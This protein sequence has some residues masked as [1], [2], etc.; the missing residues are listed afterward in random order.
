MAMHGAKT[1]KCMAQRKAMHGDK[2]KH[3]MTLKEGDAWR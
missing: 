2:R 1:K 3:C